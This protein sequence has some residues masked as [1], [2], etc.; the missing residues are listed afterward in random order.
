MYR[1]L[2]TCLAIQIV[3][4]MDIDSAHVFNFMMG[5]KAN[6]FQGIITT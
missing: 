5:H 6:T 3:Q 4:D 2:P 1:L